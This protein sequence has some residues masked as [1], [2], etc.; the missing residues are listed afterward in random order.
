MERCLHSSTYAFGYPKNFLKSCVLSTA[1]EDKSMLLVQ[2]KPLRLD[3]PETS[4]KALVHTHPR[5]QSVFFPEVK[6]S[7]EL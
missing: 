6:E 5:I 1:D 2:I 3:D 7:V 4:R